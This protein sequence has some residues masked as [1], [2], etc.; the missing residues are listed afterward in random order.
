MKYSFW[1]IFPSWPLFI[2]QTTQLLSSILKYTQMH[3]QGNAQ[4]SLRIK[5]GSLNNVCQY[6]LVVLFVLLFQLHNLFQHFVYNN[7]YTTCLT[8]PFKSQ[9]VSFLISSAH[10]MGSFIIVIII[11]YTIKVICKLNWQ[12]EEKK[13]LC[14]HK[15]YR[16]ISTARCV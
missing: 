9:V 14:V 13:K 3:K 15:K 6:L 5:N 11:I 1:S 4:R 12:F 10:Y 2:I 7:I 16:N 8:H